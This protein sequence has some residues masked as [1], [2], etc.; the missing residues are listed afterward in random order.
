[1]KKL[2]ADQLVE[3]G[4]F[5]SRVARENFISSLKEQGQFEEG[6]EKLIGLASGCAT[7]AITMAITYLQQLEQ[8]TS[9]PPK[10]PVQ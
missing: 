2:S 7:I 9:Q 5:I 4:D 8:M 10:G 1:M 6:D 3:M